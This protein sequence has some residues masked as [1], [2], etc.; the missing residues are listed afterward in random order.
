MQNHIESQVYSEGMG[1]LRSSDVWIIVM[2]YLPFKLAKGI[3]DWLAC[4]KILGHTRI[5]AFYTPGNRCLH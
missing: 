3:A 4:V 2:R 5:S 1:K